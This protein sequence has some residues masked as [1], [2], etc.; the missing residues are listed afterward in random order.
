MKALILSAILPLPS[1]QP[2]NME[3]YNVVHWSSL[4]PSF[5]GFVPLSIILI[6]PHILQIQSYHAKVED[7]CQVLVFSAALL[8]SLESHLCLAAVLPTFCHVSHAIL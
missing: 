3:Q 1:C 5:I 8:F 6:T 7:S 4:T 2:A